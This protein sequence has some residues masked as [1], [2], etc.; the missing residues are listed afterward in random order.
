MARSA[1]HPRGGG[2]PASALVALAVALVVLVAGEGC[3][4]DGDDAAQEVPTTAAPDA[5][6]G[7]SES[8]TTTTTADGPSTTRPLGEDVIDV[9]RSPEL[10]LAIPVFP[11]ERTDGE[12]TRYDIRTCTGDPALAIPD[13]QARATFKADE[14]TNVGVYHFADRPSAAAFVADY[15]D[16]LSECAGTELYEVGLG[17]D[18]Y[19]VPYPTATTEGFVLAVQ[20]GEVVW[21]VEQRSDDG[22]DVDLTEEEAFVIGQIT[23]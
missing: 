9:P 17:E 4:D 14:V 12:D 8:T 16:D 2:R 21:V 10:A 3:G 20:S 15:A 19:F 5:T 13:A 23:G 11:G 7:T 1:E 22:E 6:T 18:D